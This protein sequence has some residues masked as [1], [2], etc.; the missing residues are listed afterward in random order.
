[1]IINHNLINAQIKM[2]NEKIPPSSLP[3]SYE[4]VSKDCGFFSLNFSSSHTL[5]KHFQ[6][7][8]IKKFNE[9]NPRSSLPLSYENVSKDAAFVKRK[10]WRHRSYSIVYAR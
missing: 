6:I 1:M 7:A 2:F 8:Q 5:F 10:D 3:L 4:N 9:K